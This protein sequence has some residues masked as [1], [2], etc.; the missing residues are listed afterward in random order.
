MIILLGWIGIVCGREELEGFYPQHCHGSSVTWK[1]DA[2]I[3]GV[4]VHEPDVGPDRGWHW[5]PLCWKA[6]WAGSHTHS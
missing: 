3:A 6:G 5:G 1:G 2:R 4:P